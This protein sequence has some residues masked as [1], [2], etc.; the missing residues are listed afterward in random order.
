MRTAMRFSL[1]FM[2]YCRQAPALSSYSI[3]KNE[4]LFEQLTEI[5]EVIAEG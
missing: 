2:P 4:E 1:L 5:D 3:E